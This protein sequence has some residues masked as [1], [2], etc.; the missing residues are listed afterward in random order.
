MYAIQG[1]PRDKSEDWEFCTNC[2]E[3]PDLFYESDE[4]IIAEMDDWQDSTP[5][6]EYRIVKVNLTVE[7]Q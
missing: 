6:W 3:L 5:D 7:E 2:E 1:R 4:D